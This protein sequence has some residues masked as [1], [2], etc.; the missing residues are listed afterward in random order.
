MLVIMDVDLEVQGIWEAGRRGITKAINKPGSKARNERGAL[1][2]D[3][4]KRIG[5]LVWIKGR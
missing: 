4:F 3:L 5:E 2:V 1:S